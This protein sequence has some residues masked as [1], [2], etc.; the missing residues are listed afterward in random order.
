MIYRFLTARV[1]PCIWR[2]RRSS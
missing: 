1:K 2:L